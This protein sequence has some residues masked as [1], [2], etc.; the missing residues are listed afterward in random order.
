MKASM[1]RKV[2]RMAIASRLKFLFGAAKNR[3]PLLVTLPTD[4]RTTPAEKDREF[5]GDFRLTG[6]ASV[7]EAQSANDP[8][9]F[10]APCTPEGPKMTRWKSLVSWVGLVAGGLGMLGCLAAMVVAWLVSARL[11]RA[12]E[13][14]FGATDRV[15]AAVR[16]RTI[17]TRER[18]ANA[19][20]NLRDVEQ[21]L[22]EWTRRQ[23]AQRLP[24]QRDA[25]ESLEQLGIALAQIELWLE[26][27]ESSIRLV[28]EVTTI[29]ASTESAGSATSLAALVEEMASLRGRVAEAT[30][31]VAAIRD[32][33]SEGVDERQRDERR[34]QAIELA[35]R[36]T[37]TLGAVDDRLQTLT[38][39]LSAVQLE[40]QRWS[41][42]VQRW[43]L[44]ATIGATALIG[45]MAVG[46]MALCLVAWNGRRAAHFRDGVHGVEKAH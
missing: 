32:R 31:T 8:S 1:V 37:A 4:F 27:S 22:R 14:A 2:N 5:L 3:H 29:D 26:T 13:N 9:G 7:G 23:A 28:R 45:W 17:D 12:T 40:L 36:V 18:V 11:S 34:K 38:N 20:T 21:L 43:I 19:G 44:L 33:V 39:G 10:A 46:Q 24:S 6:T 41:R 30:A 25:D 16:Q 42:S 35:L 15:V